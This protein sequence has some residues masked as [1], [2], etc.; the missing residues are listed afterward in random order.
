VREIAAATGVST[1]SVRNA[2][3]RVAARGQGHSGLT[4]PGFCRDSQSTG[5][6]DDGNSLVKRNRFPSG[7]TQEL[8]D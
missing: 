3:G 6:W 4:R 8:G 5:E 1:F 2:L 7:F